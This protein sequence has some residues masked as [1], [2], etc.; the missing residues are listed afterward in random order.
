VFKFLQEYYF[1]VLALSEHAVTM[2]IG[3]WADLNI[4]ANT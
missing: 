3:R 4:N 2:T 1:N